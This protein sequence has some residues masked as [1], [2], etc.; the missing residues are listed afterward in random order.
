[1]SGICM[2]RIAASKGSPRR[3]HSRASVGDPVSRGTIPHEDACRLTTSRLAVLS[4]TTRRRLPRAGRAPGRVNGFESCGSF[5]L[6]GEVENRP[7][8]ALD[9]HRPAHHLAQ[10]LADREAQTGATIAA[11]RRGVHLAEGLEE[12]VDSLLR[13]ADARVPD[14]E[15]QL[16]CLRAPVLALGDALD[17]RAPLRPHR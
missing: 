7:C 6:D 1:M 14:G 10:A 9:P 3:I 16:V 17:S 5:R 15:V 11:G 2:S 13:D 12:P 8:L 4:S